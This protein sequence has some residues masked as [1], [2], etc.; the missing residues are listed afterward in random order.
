M[1][2]DILREIK[3]ENTRAKSKEMVYV[4]V[5]PVVADL[6]YGE[7]LE[8]VESLEAEIKNASWF[9]LWV[10]TI[11]SDSRFTAA[12]WRKNASKVNCSASRS[13]RK[14]ADSL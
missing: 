12:K 2:Y 1:V 11:W 13:K 8:S 10:T 3:R 14:T 7:E 9:E 5:N 4:N 6:M